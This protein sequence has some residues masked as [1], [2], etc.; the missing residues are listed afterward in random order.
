MSRRKSPEDI[1]TTS[2]QKAIDLINLKR[3]DNYGN[4]KLHDIY[5]K[6][7]ERTRGD[8]R[9]SIPNRI[10]AARMFETIGKLR[11]AAF[12]YDRATRAAIFKGWHNLAFRAGFRALMLHYELGDEM[13]VPYAQERL[14]RTIP[15]LTDLRALSPTESKSKVI[16]T[17]PS[18]GYSNSTRE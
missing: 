5:A 16:I 12:S 18:K 8:L 10:I 7:L 14:Q 11:D 6:D 13:D 15:H 17:N 4:P 3:F 9:R 1:I 2:E